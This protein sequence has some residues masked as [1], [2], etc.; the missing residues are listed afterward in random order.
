M[1]KVEDV[2]Q[3]KIHNI[4]DLQFKWFGAVTDEQCEIVSKRWYDTI[5]RTGRKRLLIES[6]NCA[7]EALY[8]PPL[9]KLH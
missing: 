2:F 5:L 7:W 3:S 8:P 1:F 4:T 6:G 9:K